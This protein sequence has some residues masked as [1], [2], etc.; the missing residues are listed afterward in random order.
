EDFLPE[1]RA[2]STVSTKKRADF[3]LSQRQTPPF[4]AWPRSLNAKPCIESTGPSLSGPS[5]KN[6]GPL[7]LI[8]VATR[9]TERNSPPNACMESQRPTANSP[10]HTTKWPKK[11]TPA[12]R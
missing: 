12:Y 8:Y 7:L 5:R 9:S 10:S 2:L 11:I 6:Q 4:E 3:L 1:G